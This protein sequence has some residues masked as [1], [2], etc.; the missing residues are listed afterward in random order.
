MQVSPKRATS[1]CRGSPPTGT[2]LAF[3]RPLVGL[4]RLDRVDRVDR[5][6]IRCHTYDTNRINPTVPLS[7]DE[8]SSLREHLQAVEGDL[9]DRLLL[10]LRWY[11]VG[12]GE[13]D[14]FNRFL[15]NWIALEAVGHHLNL[16]F[17]KV[18]PAGC[19]TCE[20]S[21]GRRDSK[22]AGLQHLFAALTGNPALSGELQ[23]A[24]NEMFHG[25]RNLE[26]LQSV[27]NGHVDTVA[28]ATARAILTLVTPDGS[29]SPE[30]LAPIRS[31]ERE[32]DIVFDATIVKLSERDR[33]GVLYQ[34]IVKL[35]SEVVSGSNAADGGPEIQAN[36]TLSGP[37]LCS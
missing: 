30:V 18:P 33:I 27:I 35:E 36:Y 37:Q 3:P 1:A 20:T 6:R 16:R 11:L 29:P 26:E 17:H 2:E 22:K 32:P 13:I 25:L 24:R 19:S 21:A 7:I 12:I 10:A 28:T 14:A 31:F 15:S 23:Q 8:W 4:E 9:F 5:Y 34:D